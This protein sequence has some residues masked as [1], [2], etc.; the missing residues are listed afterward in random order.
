MNYL[1]K[2]FLFVFLFFILS[3][4]F[5][6]DKITV[7]QSKLSLNSTIIEPF[8]GK[9]SI[10]YKTRQK[11]FWYSS[12]TAYT[13]LS[14]GLYHAWYKNYFGPKFHFFNDNNEWLQIDKV[15]HFY[16]TY[17]LSQGMYQ[18]LKWAGL[19]NN[20]SLL[21]SSLISF[22]Y[23]STIEVFDGFSDSWGASV[24]DISANVMGVGMFLLNQHRQ[25]FVQVKFSYHPTHFAQYR[26]NVLGSNAAERFIKDY[27]GQ[28]YW[29]NLNI[30]KMTGA[31]KI[32]AWIDLSFGY[33]ATG[34][35]GGDANP[36]V[37]EQNNPY[38]AFQR[39]RQ[40][41]LSLDINPKQM[42]IKNKFLKTLVG[43]FNYIKIPFPALK[44]ENKSFSLEPF[45]F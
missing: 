37:D 13:G 14:I 2:Q 43:S 11:I 5:C 22:G 8:S 34:M 1:K 17:Q 39:H 9:D 7:T 28:T 16:T 27:N 30:Q 12:A 23:M 40:Y 10:N 32:P 33:G 42:K 35:I 6:Q 44:Y 3:N 38:P 25:S 41:Y 26:P 24:G 4:S 31:K 21:Y 20:K 15:G 29:L 19:N 18:S 45:Y 36:T